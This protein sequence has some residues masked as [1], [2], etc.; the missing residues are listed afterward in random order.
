MPTLNAMQSILASQPFSVFLGAEFTDVDDGMAEITLKLKPEHCQQHGFAHGGVVSYLSDN[1]LSFAAGTVL[2]DILT[3]EMKINYVRPATGEKLV[4]RARVLS[5]GRRQAVCHCD[6]FAIGNGAEK[7][8]AV[9]QGT[10]MP[11]G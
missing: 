2:V 1:A 4:A 5:S 6:V 9:A 11:R 8:C 3:L 7:L 10:V